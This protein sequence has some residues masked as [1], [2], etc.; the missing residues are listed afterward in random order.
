MSSGRDIDIQVA[1]SV[2]QVGQEAWDRLIAGRPFASYGWYRFGEA[3]LAGSKPVYIVA[4]QKGEPLARATFWLTRQ[5][6]LPISPAPLRRLMQAFI[7]RWPLLMCRTPLA[8]ASGLILPEGALREAALTAIAQ[9]AREQARQHRA[10]FVIFDYLERPAMEELSQV[11]PFVPVEMSNP[12]TRLAIVW[13]DFQSYL[14]HL[15]KNMRKQYHRN[16]NRARDLGLEIKSQVLEQAMDRT[17]LDEALRL[18][19]NVESRHSSSPYPWARG[20]LEHAYLANAIWLTAEADKQL[21]SWCLLLRDR[22]YWY[23]SLAGLDYNA[24]YAYFQL[25][26]VLIERAIQERAQ[27]LWGGSWAYETKQR[28]GFQI[29]YDNYLAFTSPNPWLQRIGRLFA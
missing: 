19:Q 15:S 23:W 27:M 28:L 14:S 11:K 7:G 25:V 17:R 26:Y 21:S 18:F 29:V 9:A 2:E 4:S 12:G 16:L 24:R 8:C 20:M 1:H 5:E 22:D 6:Y 13:P 3:V 10:S